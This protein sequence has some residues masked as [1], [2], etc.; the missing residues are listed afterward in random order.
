MAGAM[1]VG[2][3]YIGVKTGLFAT[4]ANKGAMRSE[5][6]HGGNWIAASIRGGMA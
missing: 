6:R 2:M 4:M 1:S 5:G 3:A